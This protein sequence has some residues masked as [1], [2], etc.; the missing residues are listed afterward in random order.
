MTYDWLGHTRQA[1]AAMNPRSVDSVLLTCDKIDLVLAVK[2]TLE[3]PFIG[4]IL[5]SCLDFFAITPPD[6][7]VVRADKDGWIRNIPLGSTIVSLGGGG[8][9][10][11]PVVFRGTGGSGGGGG[12][13]LR[14]PHHP[15]GQ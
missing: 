3:V 13:I 4:P 5:E 8:G 2:A 14:Y 12:G 10:R 15:K 6:G 9:G 11:G 1:V 7:E